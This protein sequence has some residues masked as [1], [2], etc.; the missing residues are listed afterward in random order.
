M[1]PRERMLAAYR[2][3][4]PDAVPVSPELWDATAIAVS[5]RPFH[6][7]VGPFARVPWWQTHL[8]VFEYFEADAWILAAPAESDEQRAMRRSSSRFLDEETIQTTIAYHTPHGDLSATARTSPVYADWLV[9][10]PVKNW[11]QDMEAY[12][13]Y[14]FTAPETLDLGEIDPI[15]AGVGEKG[16]VTTYAGELFTS[17]LGT[18][19]EGGMAQTIFDLLDDPETCACLQ[20]RYI[21]HITA[22]TRRIL[23]ETH[24]QAILILG[25]YASLPILNRRLFQQWDIPLLAAVSAVCREFDVPLHLHQHGRLIPIMEDLISA[26]VSL[27]CP[28]LAS[29][30]GDVDD[31]LAFKQRFGGRIALKGNVDPFSILLHGAPADVEKAVVACLHAAAPNGGY[32]LGTAD[33][34]LIS[35]PFENIRAFVEAGRKYGKYTY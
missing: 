24:T 4:Q 34:T 22:L 2:L 12:G 7:L 9:E 29:P 19:R 33:S 6:E 30:Q 31:L 8:A 26:G 13:D 1:N 11:P 28:L 5:G 14:F 16:L 21:R 10:H 17:F 32:I 35:T 3:Q 23:I 27:V 20:Q 15:I 25:G 18:L